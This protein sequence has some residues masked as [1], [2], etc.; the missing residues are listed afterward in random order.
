M[1]LKL[2][3]QYARIV[4][5]GLI[6]A[7]LLAVGGLFA[8]VSQAALPSG[9]SVSGW[10]PGNISVAAFEAALQAKAAALRAQPVQLRVS[11]YG[12]PPLQTTY[13]QLGLQT[14]EAEL[15]AQAAQLR[16]GPWWQRAKQRWRL[17]HAALTLRVELPEAAL[18]AALKPAWRPLY[19]ALPTNAQR[20]ITADDRV[21]YVAGK[22]VPRVDAAPLRERLLA[23]VPPLASL[24]A[25]GAKSQRQPIALD[26]PL[27]QEAPKVTVESLKAEGVER[28]FIQFSTTYDRS[29]E[30]R[31]YNIEST[32]KVVNDLYLKPG[33]IFDYA[34]VIEQTEAK[35]G[36]KEAPVI[37]NGKLVPG[38]GGGICQVSTTLYNAVLRSGLEIVERRNHS[39]PVSYVPLG[40]DA[41][42]STGYINFR[43]RNNTGNGLLI[44][45]EMNG[46]RL[47]VKLFGKTPDDIT[48]D[49]DS[50]IVKVIEPPLKYVRNDSLKRGETLRLIA[51]K[52]GYIV[53][54]KRY[55]K[56]N[57]KV[58]GE[59]LISR[60]TYSAQPTV[61]AS[62]T[63]TE[64]APDGAN[65]G[66]DVPKP[67]VEDGVQGPKFQ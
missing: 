10:K 55:K 39:L 53:E 35:Y 40:L 45:T 28:K 46:G 27:V 16:S 17:R 60:D 25:P 5:A 50:K 29:M 43:F 24:G 2:P 6:A 30:G 20:I 47:T 13:G 49:L 3:F 44:R 14:G 36:Y 42:F 22:P 26:V 65:D 56:Q 67:H 38:V 64:G 48:Y 41:T 54:T 66:T 32:A 23:A 9:L 11:A 31:Q 34:K 62:N 33:D 19:E 63:G 4:L 8:Y 21:A 52:P 57:G 1:S 59:E 58:V 37:L 7:L 61:I 12:L 18:A 15:L 51:G